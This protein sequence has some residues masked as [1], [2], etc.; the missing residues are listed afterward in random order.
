M[1]WLLSA[2]ILLIFAIWIIYKLEWFFIFLGINWGK[3]PNPFTE[4]LKHDPPHQS[5]IEPQAV[6]DKVLRKGFL[7]KHVPDN[8]DAIIIGS[9][10]GGL[11]TGALLAKLGKRVLVLEQHDR[12]GGCLHV[13]EDKGYLFD[14]GIHIIGQLSEGMM[15]TILIDQITDGQIGW[16][17]LPE[18]FDR[19]VIGSGDERID[20][21]VCSSLT[22]NKFKDDLVKRF[23]NETK[24]IE[25]YFNM[26]KAA[27]L[28]FL[29]AM[30]TKFMPKKLIL[31]L[32][33]LNL[34]NRI[35]KYYNY[36]EVSL[37]TVV[38]SLIDDKDLQ[39]ILYY[40]YGDYG[41]APAD[42]P[43]SMH[44]ILQQHFIQGAYFPVGGPS[45][46]AYHLIQTI[47][48]AGGEVLVRAKC[49]EILTST[50]QCKAIGVCVQKGSES[51][52]ILAPIVIS[53]A[54]LHNTY[55]SLLNASVKQKYLLD[56][57]CNKF[58][59]GMTCLTAFIG[60]KGSN[61]E[62]NLSATNIWHQ[63]SNAT[64][65][66]LDNFCNLSMEDALEVDLPILFI[67]FPS[68][69]D[70][71]WSAHFP[72]KSVCEVISPVPYRWFEDW[73][74]DYTDGKKGDHY[75]T[76][77]KTFGERMWSQTLRIFPQLK[78]KVDY[79][80]L[81]TPLTN[82]FYLQYAK[83]EIYGIDHDVQRFSGAN[84]CYLK[85]TTPIN[86][87][88]LTGQDVL[89]CGFA[90]ALYGGVL[91]A[92]AILKRNLLLDLVKMRIEYKKKFQKGKEKAKS[93]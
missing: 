27:R 10:V 51:I 37:K 74:N 43:F 90:G 88:Y 61:E 62:L 39:A 60:L 29:P 26:Q 87:L 63:V 92:S 17:T 16:N 47:R 77:K 18:N 69:K 56:G 32:R 14:V 64:Q 72:G 80:E 68:T 59:P 6:R 42:A 23:P 58:N 34:L 21:D 86:G 33:K 82:S 40:N 22:G 15:T 19:V 30:L 38:E 93:D 44:A 53:N 3:G 76:L 49:T 12:A 8:L 81:G 85:S 65:Q 52:N 20:F 57:V 48:K 89:S 66:D 11:S 55:N 79:F 84:S 67:S 46:V 71:A 5:T 83:G 35:F 2:C 1:Y 7:P 91:C 41:T 70:P 54:G 31:I 25:K 75:L 24:S 13:Y 45:N 4:V 50:D 73:R 36:C 78:D 9:G 28:S